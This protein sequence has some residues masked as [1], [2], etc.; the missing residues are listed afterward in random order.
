MNTNNTNKQKMYDM[1][2]MFKDRCM[3]DLQPADYIKAKYDA[4]TQLDMDEMYEEM[5][6]LDELD[7]LL[8]IWEALK[9]QIDYGEIEDEEMLKY[10]I[11]YLED[12]ELTWSEMTPEEGADA[13]I[14]RIIENYQEERT[15][16]FAAE[17]WDEM[18]SLLRNDWED[19]VR[20]D[21]GRDP[22]EWA[23]FMDDLFEFGW[24]EW[25]YSLEEYVRD[26]YPHGDWP[27]EDVKESVIEMLKQSSIYE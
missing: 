23:D 5:D 25:E 2:D 3:E 18:M 19:I 22:E 7:Y 21:L 16:A 26:N 17:Y 27:E 4:G 14:T 20:D 15:A 8:D 12:C 10:V 13:L 6:R 11:D 9:R 1:V 24:D